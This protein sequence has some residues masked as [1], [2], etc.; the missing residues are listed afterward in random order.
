MLINARSIC[1]KLA[2]LQVYVEHYKPAVIAIAESWADIHIPDSVLA[3]NNYT[4]YRKDRVDRVGGGVLLYVHKTFCST[5]VE[6]L[7]YGPYSESV[8]CEIHLHPGATTLIGTIYRPPNCTKSQDKQLISLLKLLEQKQNTYKLVSGDF[9]LPTINWTTNS[10]TAEWD[11]LME[12]LQDNNLTQHVYFPTRNDA[13]LDLIFSDEPHLVTLEPLDTSD[14]NIVIAELNMD[15]KN[16]QDMSHTRR[17]FQKADWFLFQEHL[18]NVD[19]NFVF[20]PTNVD[21]VVYGI[22]FQQLYLI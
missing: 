20:S 9:N 10:Y 6:D 14:H 16:T 17:Q 7:T 15:N 13:I 21:T 18:Y 3:L 2:I 22:I 8:W 12:A 5:L 19:W 11:E 4:L 1:N